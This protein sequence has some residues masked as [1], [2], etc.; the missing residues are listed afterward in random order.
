MNMKQKLIKGF[1]LGIL[2]LGIM[3]MSS[4]VARANTINRNVNGCNFSAYTYANQTTGTAGTSGTSAS[5]YVEVSADYAY[6]NVNTLQTGS[7]HLAKAGSNSVYVSFVA[8][9]SCH[10]VYTEANHYARSGSESWSGKTK[11][12]Y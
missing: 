12:T 2:A 8:P 10:T 5:L 11:E 6:V 3:G 9:N 7:Y 1:T 4:N